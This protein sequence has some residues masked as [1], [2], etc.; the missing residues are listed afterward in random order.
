MRERPLQKRRAG[1]LPCAYEP[2]RVGPT[3]ATFRRDFAADSLQ[4]QLRA[5]SRCKFWLRFAGEQ[6]RRLG[7]Y[8]LAGR[9]SYTPTGS[10]AAAAVRCSHCAADPVMLRT[11]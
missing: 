4:V 6:R 10:R 7:V 3:P 1:N 9:L 8:R 11:I 5:I 2:L